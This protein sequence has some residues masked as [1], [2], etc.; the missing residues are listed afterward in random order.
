MCQLVSFNP[1]KKKSAFHNKG[2]WVV[3]ISDLLLTGW[4]RGRYIG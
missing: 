1:F 3:P 2:N 4:V